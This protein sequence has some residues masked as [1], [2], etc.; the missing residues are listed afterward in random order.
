MVKQVF[1]IAACALL[2]L[3]PS[4]GIANNAD[5][6]RFHTGSWTGI[7]NEDGTGLYHEILQRIYAPHGIEVEVTYFPVKRA[8]MNVANGDADMAGA[9]NKADQGQ[10]RAKHPIWVSMNCALFEKNR[11][12]EWNGL[13]TIE[14]NRGRVVSSYGM[15]RMV[16]VKIHEVTTRTQ[17]LNM[18]LD[19]RMDY[20]ADTQE[21]LTKLLAGD[22]TV[23]GFEE[24]KQPGEMPHF[25]RSLY[26]VRNIKATPA[27]MIFSDTDRGRRFRDIFDEGFKKLHES[28]ELAKIYKNWNLESVMPKKLGE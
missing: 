3:L 2:V 26:V 8:L 21:T 25:K 27:Y 28:G 6:L 23:I 22:T 18:M 9:T 19:G 5:T 17:A 10:I 24:G 12:S 14:E 4:R 16:G 20:Y 13:Q 15:G 7:T 11:L 1:L